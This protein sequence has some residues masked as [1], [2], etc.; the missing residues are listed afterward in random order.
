[1]PNIDTT[2]HHGLIVRWL[3][4]GAKPIK[5]VNSSCLG[6][7]GTAPDADVDIFPENEPI[8]IL[9]DSK[10][11]SLGTSGTLYNAY[12]NILRQCATGGQ[13]F[14]PSIIVVRVKEEETLEAQAATMIGTAAAKTGVYAFNNAEME[15]GECPSILIA[16][17]F[18]GPQIDGAYNPITQALHDVGKKFGAITIKDG[19]G[20]TAEEIY[21]DAKL[22][23]SKYIYYVANKGRI[24][25][26]GAAQ[27]IYMPAS[28]LAAGMFALADRAVGFWDSPSNRVVN[29]I[30]GYNP[31][32]E[33]NSQQIGS[34]I[35]YLNS[36]GVNVL[37]FE[38]GY[39]LWGSRNTEVINTAEQF[40]TST[41]IQTVLGKSILQGLRW[42]IDRGI[43]KQNIL[44]VQT[45]LTRFLRNF[46]GS[47]LYEGTQVYIDPEKNPW[48]MVMQGQFTFDAKYQEVIPL[49][50]AVID[51]SR[52]NSLIENFVNSVLATA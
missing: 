52:D 9:T 50:K 18:G 44:D 30:N 47:A 3:E 6:I 42:A 40:I 35:D 49:E 41:R 16:P 2:Y 14:R 24:F 7:I 25:D 10:A 19:F 20:D 15:I 33:G 12:A 32:F 43:N 34:E 8:Q 11:A 5:V 13:N 4:G 1:M 36:K 37:N 38:G 27:N 28:S 51:M 39:R 29:G 23:A 48:D 17:G 31:S 26:V 21:N 46:E 22:L 45:S